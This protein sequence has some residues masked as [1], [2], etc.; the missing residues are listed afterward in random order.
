MTSFGLPLVLLAFGVAG[1]AGSKMSMA[2]ARG[3]SRHV[4]QIAIAPGS[5]PFADAIVSDS[6]NSRSRAPEVYLLF[7]RAESRP[8]SWRVASL[9][10]MGHLRAAVPEWWRPRMAPS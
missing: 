1:C 7:G 4:S 2:Q 3:P 9:R 6:T 10:T 8:S 5:G